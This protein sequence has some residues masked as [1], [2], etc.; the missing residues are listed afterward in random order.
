MLQIIELVRFIVVLLF[1][2]RQESKLW[3]F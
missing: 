2:R 3:W 1:L